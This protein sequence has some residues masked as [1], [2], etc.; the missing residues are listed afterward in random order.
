M[1][2]VVVPLLL[3]GAC[4]AGIT[5][6]ASIDKQLG[7]QQAVVSF[8]D[9]T[10]NTVR[11]QV[12]SA[13]GKLPNVSPVPLPAGV[14]L[15]ESLSQVTFNVTSADDAQQARLQECLAKFKSV[16]GLDFEDSTD[17]GN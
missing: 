9:G 16:A 5:G 13:C 6:C 11:L 2:R 4:V 7:Q 12:R 8:Q 17:M 1:R 15:S 3:A 14:P 10:S